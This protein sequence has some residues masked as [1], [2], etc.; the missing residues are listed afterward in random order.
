MQKQKTLWELIQ[1]SVQLISQP[2]SNWYSV[3]C[4]VCNDHAIRAAFVHDGHSTGY[5]CFNCHAAF[6][7]EEGTGEISFHAR[8]V[9]RTFGLT[10]TDFSEVSSS[11][12]FDEPKEITLAHMTAISLDTPTVKFPSNTFQIGSDIRPDLQEP[13]IAYLKS[14]NV[15]PTK[16]WFSLDEKHLRRV[17]I[18]FWRNGNLIYW[19]SRAIDSDCRPKY[20]NPTVNRNPIFYNFDQLT[21]YTDAPLFVT[22]GVFDSEMVNGISILGSALSP[23]KIELLKNSKRHLIFVVDLDHAGLVL[24]KQAISH[25]WDITHV[26]LD[27]KDISDSVVKYGHLY[28]VHSLIANTSNKNDSQEQKE[29]QLE[30]AIMTTGKRHGT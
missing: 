29:F 28:T 16:F 17:I 1:Q 24:G 13:L 14:R 3:R 30:L 5:N 6:R 9:L 19:Q 10:D 27:A 8:K 23:A 22:E 11:A 15:K 18:P 25:G 21:R 12:F 26:N 7:Y 2:N 20:R 4:P